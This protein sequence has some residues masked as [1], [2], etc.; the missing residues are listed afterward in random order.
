M[1]VIA[2]YA[3]E[4]I[5]NLRGDRHAMF[6]MGDFPYSVQMSDSRYRIF[7]KSLECCKCGLRGSVMRLEYNWHPRGLIEP[8][9]NLYALNPVNGTYVL[10]T[11]DH[12]IPKSKGGSNRD[13]NLRTMCAPCNEK[14]GD[15]HASRENR[16]GTQLYAARTH[17]SGNAGNPHNASRVH[18][19]RVY[20][21]IRDSVLVAGE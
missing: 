17:E 2:E 18:S 14:K 3:P 4:E 9:F 7:A 8:H 13:E 16:E 19:Y 10:M 11:Q 5:L 20:G 6:H 21:P 1:C 12:V 15:K